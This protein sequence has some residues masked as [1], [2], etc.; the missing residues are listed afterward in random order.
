MTG[1][2]RGF[3]RRCIALV[4][5]VMAAVA[6]CSAGSTTPDAAPGLPRFYDIAELV[7]AVAERQ[8]TDQT[9]RL[10][11]R[12]ELIGAATLR[13]TGEGVLRVTTDEVS[14]K[15]TQIVTQKGVAPQETG[16]VVLPGAVYLRLP[17]A[18]GDPEAR[19]W[20]RVDPSSTDPEAKRLVTT[21]AA[22]TESADPTRTL[23]R[24]TDATLIADAVDDVIEGDPAVR[25]TIVVDLARAAAQQSDPVIKAQLE[26]QVRGG[27]TRVTSTLWVDGAN[28]PLRTAV[29]QELPGI[30]TLAITGS[31][32][33]WGQPV[34][35]SPPPAEQV[36]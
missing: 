33:E 16:F 4:I 19:P 26:Q 6:G 29:R 17:P 23:S 35:I 21:A 11:L 22:V 24:Y 36:R 28:R 9:A 12:G 20:V 1:N 25:Y 14:V 8:R 2:G 13:F 27:L 15:F 34:E 3:T 18:A 5:V 10:S 30:G 7:A 32:R 31:Y